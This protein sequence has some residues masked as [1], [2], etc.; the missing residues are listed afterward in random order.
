MKK[1]VEIHA[2]H[3]KAELKQ[4]EAKILRGVLE[5]PKKTVAEIMT[6]VK[7]A[8]MLD[9]DTKLDVDTVTKIWQTGRS[10][11]P[12]YHK[13]KDNIVGMLF[14][15][16][17]VVINQDDELPLSTILAFYGREVIKVFPDTHLD[18][19]MKIFKSGRGHLAIVHNVVEPES[20]DPYYATVGLVTLEDVIEEILR[21]EIVDESDIYVD[22]Q[23]TKKVAREQ[24]YPLNMFAKRSKAHRLTPKQ[25]IAVGSYLSK[26]VD[27]FRLL[28]ETILHKLLGTASLLTMDVDPTKEIFLYKKNQ[29]CDFFI[30]VLNGK[31]EVISGKEQFVSELGPWSSVGSLA[32]TSTPYV[33]D[34]DC[35]L[36]KS[37][38]LV[39]IYR[40]DYI[41]A[42]QKVAQDDKNFK[43]PKDMEWILKKK[44]EQESKPR[45]P[46]IAEKV[47]NVQHNKSGE[48][49]STT[50]K[51]EVPLQFNEDP[52]VRS[53][54]DSVSVDIELMEIS[55][56]V[57]KQ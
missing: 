45:S 9:I 57:K 23:N 17:L 43:L 5:Y 4:D 50:S 29:E 36:S 51:T 14:T 47:D 13:N 54:Q 44:K 20:G 31:L 22:N 48:T 25:V 42:V 39:K 32:L 7:D 55:S 6:P 15:K 16:D 26:S 28:P 3:V 1:L 10:R 40:E 30:L 52:N 21:E 2:G 56:L 24:R 8:F 41:K 53:S 11:I 49:K 46:S 34:F 18:E 38:Q 27:A 12:I 35:K 33:P 37:S 19:M